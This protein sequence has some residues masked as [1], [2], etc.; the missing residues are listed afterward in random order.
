MEYFTKLKDNHF[1]DLNWNLPER[2]QGSINIIGGNAKSFRT[3]IKIAEYLDKNSPVKDI[4]V[5]L[6][7]KLVGELPKLPNFVFVP[8]TDSGSLD[9]SEELLAVMNRADYN[10]VLGD[11]SKNSI[12]GRA[13]VKALD[14]KPTI[15]TRDAVDLVTEHLTDETL[16]N[17]GLTIF[18]SMPQLI[19][20]F[21][22]VFYPKMLLMSQ[23]LM[24]V[25]EVLHKFTLSYPV[26]IITLHSGQVIIARDGKVTA[27]PIEE[28]DYSPITIWGGELAARIAVM[29]LFN[30]E[31]F[32]DATSAAVFKTNDSR[33]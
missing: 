24:Q 23:P 8:S 27:I 13:V 26:G 25:V 29:N 6:P 20:L 32:L 33:R 10:L 9:E 17:E 31:N 16:M 21:H 18:A 11:L 12:T 19:K 15:I 1:E 4:N 30:P 5:V 14:G 3:E 2:K 22:A 7:D 28:T